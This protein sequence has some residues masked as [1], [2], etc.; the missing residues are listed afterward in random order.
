MSVTWH[1]TEKILNPTTREYQWYK[2]GECLSTDAK[3]NKSNSNLLN[4]SKLQEIDTGK[5]YL[6][7]ADADNWVVFN[8]GSGGGGGG[9]IDPEDVATDSEVNEMFNDVFGTG[10]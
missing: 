7:N 4:G 1:F 6:Y 3:P 8:D 5:T 9:D 2:K 10:S